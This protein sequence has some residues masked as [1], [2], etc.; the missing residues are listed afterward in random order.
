MK[1][2]EVYYFPLMDA[3]VVIEIYNNNTGAVMYSNIFGVGLTSVTMINKY[4][5]KIGKL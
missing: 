2:G 5:K 1:S 4:Y 3:L